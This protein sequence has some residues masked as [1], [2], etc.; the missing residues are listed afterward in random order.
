MHLL[1]GVQGERVLGQADLQVG[2]TQLGLSRLVKQDL[3]VVI[4]GHGV[5]DHT[6]V[7]RRHHDHAH[8]S[9]KHSGGKKGEDFDVMKF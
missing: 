2:V 1:P 4:A 5:G 6:I 3:G 9:E 7:T 8:R